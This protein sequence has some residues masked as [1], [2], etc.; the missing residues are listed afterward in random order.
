MDF[1]VRNSGVRR[2]AWRWRGLRCTMQCDFSS[3][4]AICIRQF[5]DPESPLEDVLLHGEGMILTLRTYNVT[6]CA[7][8]PGKC[9]RRSPYWTLAK[10][11]SCMLTKINQ[12]RLAISTT[13]MGKE[14]QLRRFSY[15]A[16][17]DLTNSFNQWLTKMQS[18]PKESNKLPANSSTRRL[19]AD[20]F[21]VTGVSGGTG[22]ETKHCHH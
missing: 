14:S 9:V 5:T 13:V 18:A 6:W 7:V 20:G 19:L 21:R 15:Y 3:T 11:F 1:I 2:W 8:L 12:S 17:W 4:C 22:V 16:R 10:A